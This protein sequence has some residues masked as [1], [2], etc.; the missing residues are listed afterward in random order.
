MVTTSGY[1]A[2]GGYSP[3]VAFELEPANEAF[4]DSAPH[5]Y[6]FPMD[7]PA[8][9]E[10]VW[11]GLIAD[12]PLAW[13]RGLRIEWTSARPFGVGTT[14]TAH[15]AFGAVK[16]FERY[17]VWDEGRRTVFSVERSNVPLFRRFAE[18]YV[19]EPTAAGCR[20]TW[21]FAA[22]P[23]GPAAVRAIDNLMQR[24]IFGAMARDTRRHFRA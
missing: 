5:R 19:I 18:D 3:A 8:P 24:G 2:A 14:R 12:P 16:L 21:T 6:V 4:L 7:L 22:E 9:A 23:R 11:A 1:Q 15:G 20:F 13:V 17:I 10:T